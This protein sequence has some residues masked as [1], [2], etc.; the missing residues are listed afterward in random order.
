MNVRHAPSTRA[1]G[2][3]LAALL[4][5]FCLSSGLA[6]APAWGAVA[7]GLDIMLIIDDSGSMRQSKNDKFYWR[8]KAAMV[9][10]AYAQAR[11]RAAIV[12]YDGNAYDLLPGFWPLTPAGKQHIYG[13]VK[14]FSYGGKT[15]FK[16]AFRKA[17]E[18]LEGRRGE[19]ANRGVVV[20]FLT[21]GKGKPPPAP[22]DLAFF[23]RKGWVVNGMALG[24]NADLKQVSKI[25]Q[26]TGGVALKS[27][28]A[29][30]IM[31]FFLDVYQAKTGEVTSALAVKQEN[32]RRVLTP[33]ARIVA[34]DTWKD[35][36]L[37][38]LYGA[39][40][41]RVEEIREK[42]L[43]VWTA[44][45]GPLKP[46]LK[47][48]TSG[49][50]WFFNGRR[51]A[52]AAVRIKNPD[53]TDWSVV[54]SGQPVAQRS[55]FSPSVQGV[56]IAGVPHPQ[57]RLAAMLVFR[58]DEGNVV[59]NEKFYRAVVSVEADLKLVGIDQVLDSIRLARGEGGPAA[60]ARDERKW[61]YWGTF[62]KKPAPEIPF[63]IEYTVTYADGSIQ[64]PLG[65][66][67]T[68]PRL[69]LSVEPARFVVDAGADGV[70]L[71]ARLTLVGELPGGEWNIT[72]AERDQKP[73][74]FWQ[75][76]P[77]RRRIVR[78]EDI[79]AQ[80]I[81]AALTV[82]QLSEF[83]AE[84]TVII[85]LPSFDIFARG[86][87]QGE[88]VLQAA[89][90]NDL[91]IAPATIS[92]EI[93]RSSGLDLLPITALEQRG[94]P[95]ANLFWGQTLLIQAQVRNALPTEYQ[96]IVVTLTAPDGSV[97]PLAL[98]RDGKL[99][100]ATVPARKTG[101]YRAVLEPPADGAYTVGEGE[102]AVDVLPYEAAVSVAPKNITLGQPVEMTV[103]LT[104]A[105]T[106][107]DLKGEVRRPD[108]KTVSVRLSGRGGRYR[109][110][111]ANTD[112]AGSY[113]FRLLPHLGIRA[114]PDSALFAIGLPNATF[115][116]D[117]ATVSWG[118][119]AVVR[120]S[121]F[122]DAPPLDTVQ[123]IATGPGQEAETLTLT[124]QDK[125]FTLRWTPAMVGRYVLEPSSAT[126]ARLA[127][128]PPRLTID[129]KPLQGSLTAQADSPYWGT[130][131]T[132]RARLQ[133]AAADLHQKIPAV[134]V[135]WTSPGA[136][137]KTT[138]KL[139]PQLGT[140]GV[141]AVKLDLKTTGTHVFE[142]L[143]RSM[144]QFSDRA[145]T[146]RIVVKPLQGSLTA[147]AD[148][149]Y[150]GASTTLRARL[151]PAA[152][153]LHQK[154]PAI[155][156]RWTSPGVKETETVKLT[157]Q[158]GTPGVYVAKLDL[159]APGT[160][161]FEA[162]PR[163][164]VQFGDRAAT[165]RVSVKQ[166]QAR[167][168]VSPEGVLLDW[169]AK[170]TAH[171]V[172]EPAP[173]KN[174]NGLGEI[175]L[176]IRETGASEA[177]TIALKRQEDGRY[178]PASPLLL[179]LDQP[180]TSWQLALP[181]HPQGAYAA[182]EPLTVSRGA[183][184]KI[185][186]SVSPVPTNDPIELAKGQEFAITVTVQAIKLFKPI[187]HKVSLELSGKKSEQT[188]HLT[189][190]KQHEASAMVEFT[191]TN[192]QGELPW[193]F[194]QSDPAVIT[195]G[196]DSPKPV[197]TY[198]V[199]AAVPAWFWIAL[200]ATAGLVVLVVLALVVRGIV[201]QPKWH[202]EWLVPE[203]PGKAPL[204]LAALARQS[205][206][207]QCHVDDL[208]AVVQL[209]GS[210]QAPELFL[211]PAPNRSSG[212]G[213]LEV[214]GNPVGEGPVRLK[215]GDRLSLQGADA[216]VYVF[217]A[218]PG[219]LPGWE[220]EVL[221]PLTS[222]GAPLWLKEITSSWEAQ[223]P[224]IGAVARR[225]S[226]QAGPEY[227]IGVAPQ[228]PAALGRIEI[229]GQAAADSAPL[230]SGQRV[231]VQGGAQYIFQ[232]GGELPSWGL[233]VLVCDADSDRSIY[234]A[235]VGRQWEANADAVGAIIRKG[236]TKEQPLYFIRAAADRQAFVNGQALSS[237]A[238]AKFVALNP[239]DKV[240]AAGEGP[241]LLRFQADVDLS[242]LS[243]DIVLSG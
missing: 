69:G 209:G 9:I 102:Q 25:C 34:G 155:D 189:P 210:R 228:R 76:T 168:T 222:D 239:G 82:R 154:V 184:P 177:R 19:N 122:G 175:T 84:L 148:S 116:V 75:E 33:K 187:E 163:S 231:G 114:R 1:T 180:E 107:D 152:A 243:D 171:A 88:I 139:T 226:S 110:T 201:R 40:I 29:K 43:V 227:Q 132:L 112:A 140:P 170:L 212:L 70:R 65:A 61:A 90:T 85:P 21:D 93:S 234:L 161:V 22:E 68:I 124:H 41:G 199:R 2:L 7:E 183:R 223:I 45:R 164:M 86:K 97:Q 162:L 79:R 167:L 113:V 10:S 73:S 17:R 15:N 229:E 11:D 220:D 179:D 238:E 23:R 31:D 131:A 202:D 213:R 36:T 27:L 224:G 241:G 219:T 158:P 145:A 185:T 166:Y 216:P 182:T 30:E 67:A 83:N 123:V 232:R 42:G 138:V 211:T 242:E 150:W 103:S 38:M 81:P 215:P 194:G 165:A 196:T 18:V 32:G 3:V 225:W 172:L 181:A 143:P 87:C 115:A 48:E 127:L 53:H 12:V 217:T 151:E 134:D 13:K 159:K 214:N 153:D 105:A 188:V 62:R 137:M 64:R 197:A 198:Q 14:R 51:G 35:L 109:A 207:R 206:G 96:E 26:L 146:A 20:L 136:K 240:G 156:V 49:V 119:E 208:G 130:S 235:R 46:G 92:V 39:K 200:A 191:L 4:A 157:P 8:K 178:Q 133:P 71:I 233:E 125:Q 120:V 204:Q 66:V 100:T 205:G 95:G 195:S 129:V 55:A 89:A 142:A 111:F 6:P 128:S 121:D 91:V 218:D 47:V 230:Q 176:S 28:E 174:I 72:V 78:A 74:D 118:R 56:P 104:P 63:V 193:W 101:T 203:T 149:P 169:D 147:Q 192:A 98:K 50:R 37:V 160:H 77:K 99:F 190:D 58:D 186:V 108:G 144:V 24:R 59:R 135:R 16:K 221:V 237:G 44:D 94:A 52:F 126:S 141:Y 54:V 5:G 117:P 106:L 173:P 60:I 57:R 80:A 236:G